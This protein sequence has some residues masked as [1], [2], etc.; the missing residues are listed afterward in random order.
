MITAVLV[1]PV[2]CWCI[3]YILKVKIQEEDKRKRKDKRR[4]RLLFS[5]ICTYLPM[6]VTINYKYS[7]YALVTDFVIFKIF[8]LSIT[9]Y[10]CTVKVREKYHFIAFRDSGSINSLVLR[11]T[12]AHFGI[13]S[14][15]R[16]CLQKRPWEELAIFYLSQIALK[17]KKG[18]G[19]LYHTVEH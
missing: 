14:S 17:W 5:L 16:K 10:L 1:T 7:N 19:I 9:F 18:G 6:V 4:W 3:T 11:L 2:R 8:L 12:W 13:K 15:F